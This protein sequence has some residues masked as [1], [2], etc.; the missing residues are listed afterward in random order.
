MWSVHA[1]LKEEDV[2][3]AFASAETMKGMLIQLNRFPDLQDM[4]LTYVKE[5]MI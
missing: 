2:D 4:I 1:A 5:T 3:V